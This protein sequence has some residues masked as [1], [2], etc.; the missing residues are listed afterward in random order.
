MALKG[1]PQKAPKSSAAGEPTGVVPTLSLLLLT[2][3]LTNPVVW[4]W[5][6][7]LDLSFHLLCILKLSRFYSVSILRFLP[8]WLRPCSVCEYSFGTL[9]W[10]WDQRVL[11]KLANLNPFLHDH[12]LFLWNSVGVFSIQLISLE[13]LSSGGWLENVFGLALLGPSSPLKTGWDW[14]ARCLN[15]ALCAVNCL[16]CLKIVLYSSKNI[17]KK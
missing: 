10:F 9:V 6:F 14:L 5:V 17:P 13:E 12:R 15:W 3:F 7:L 11:L 8:F 16:S 4:G 1:D 2:A